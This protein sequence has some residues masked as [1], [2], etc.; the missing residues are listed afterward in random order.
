MDKRK[1]NGGHSTKAKGVDRRKNEYK[2]ALSI[3]GDVDSVVEVLKML[4]DKAINKKDTKAASIYLSYYLGKPVETKDVTFKG[5]IPIYD[6]SDNNSN[7]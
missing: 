6:L 7:P 4:H 1:N 3:A 5:D 2:E